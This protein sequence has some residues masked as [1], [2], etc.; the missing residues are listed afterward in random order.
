[1]V[2]DKV[3]LPYKIKAIK[4]SEQKKGY[5]EVVMEPMDP[6]EYNHSDEMGQPPI[7]VSGVG[8]NGSPFPPEMQ[9]Q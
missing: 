4:P 1:M 7:Q 5:V 3:T 9:H 8:P 6:L 2:E